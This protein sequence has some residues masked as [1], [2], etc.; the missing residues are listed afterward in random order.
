MACPPCPGVLL[1]LIHPKG[2]TIPLNCDCYIACPSPPLGCPQGQGLSLF[3][4]PLLS[5]FVRF[6]F[7]SWHTVSLRIY[8]L[9]KWKEQQSK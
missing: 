4:L 9:S 1:P 2:S 3:C 7:K 6:Q 5:N 8:E